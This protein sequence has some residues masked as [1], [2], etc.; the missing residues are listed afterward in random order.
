MDSTD[1]WGIERAHSISVVIPVYQ[2][3]RTLPG[4]LAEIAPLAEEFTTAAGHRARI[5]EV[6]LV[7][8]DGPDNSPAVMRQLADRFG[9]VR[10]IWLSRNFGQHSATLAGMASAGGD[11]IVTLDEDGQHDPR[12]I[13]AMLDAAMAERA[14]VV[15]GNPTNTPPHGFVRNLASSTAKRMMRLATAQI[16]ARNFQSFRL[17]LG[18]IGRSVAAYA[19]P[20]VYLDVAMAWVARRTVA[21]P[22]ELRDDS[23]RPSG[24]SLRSLSSHFWRMVVSSGTRALRLVSL[25]G[26]VFAL[27]GLLLALYFAIS[28]LFWHA[29]TPPGWPSLM[30][31]LL[32]CS[33]AILFSVGVIAEYIGVAVNMAMGKPLYL[34]VSDPADGPLG[35]NALPAPQ[36]DRPAEQSR[37][38]DSAPRHGEPV[39]PR[40]N[41]TRT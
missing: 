35:R 41:A 28:K 8:D 38:V 16:D 31:V 3:E 6:L 10:N 24:Y 22:I 37:P 30:V 36:P 12:F 34:I 23:A 11:W 18:E 9:F 15:Y 17:V 7:H 39:R 14:D 29:Q 33:G 20:G 19:G 40:D 5:D 13:P 26:I 27:G 1:A 25:L 4:L 2:G 32:V 21:V